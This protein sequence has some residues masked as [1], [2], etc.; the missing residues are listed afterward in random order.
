M[1]E[2]YQQP[3][4][5]TSPHPYTFMCTDVPPEIFVDLTCRYYGFGGEG[6][7]YSLISVETLKEYID[8]PGYFD[9]DNTERY[10]KD[11]VDQFGLDNGFVIFTHESE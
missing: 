3:D 9:A 6:I 5:H 2:E 8:D 7:D 4:L 1:I 11:V 10:I